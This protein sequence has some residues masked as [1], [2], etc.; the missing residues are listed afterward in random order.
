MR[1]K[2]VF[3]AAVAALMVGG[4]TLSCTAHGT[5]VAE[6]SPSSSVAA[7]QPTTATTSATTVA[8]PSPPSDDEQIRQ[9]ITAFQDAHNT[10]NWD[11]Y[12]A[13]MCPSMRATFTDPVMAE[14]RRNREAWG[15]TSVKILSI[16]I[17][18]DTATANIESTNELVGTNRA[19][20]KLAHGDDGWKICMG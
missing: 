2:Q 16:A 10:K 4:T 7:G 19:D 1:P 9:A 15:I 8:P 3:A 5:P 12:L 20:L 14:V 11:A 6:H 18:G 13:A 17:T